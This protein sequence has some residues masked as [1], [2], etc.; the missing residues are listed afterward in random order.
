[1]IVFGDISIARWAPSLMQCKCHQCIGQWLLRKFG[2]PAGSDHNV[3][4]STELI[5]HGCRMS[6]CRQ[7][8]IPQT[9][10]LSRHRKARMWGSKAVAAMNTK[11]PAV[12]MGPPKL[13]VPGG[14]FGPPKLNVP[15]GTCQRTSPC[16][17]ST[18]AS[19]PHGGAHKADS[20]AR[21]R[22]GGTSH[23]APQTAGHIHRARQRAPVSLDPAPWRGSVVPA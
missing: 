17:R 20:R 1:M 19:V 22:D 9:R 11:S 14:P 7:N 15:S 10:G 8:R 3:L 6:R 2:M 12:T 13:M 5:R 23:K 18:A 16:T 21:A 4:L